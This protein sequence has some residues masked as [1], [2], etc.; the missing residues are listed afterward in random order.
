MATVFETTNSFDLASAQVLDPRFFSLNYVARA[1]PADPYGPPPIAP[2]VPFMVIVGGLSSG[3]QDY[4]SFAAESG[5]QIDA[6]VLKESWSTLRVGLYFYDSAGFLFAS[7][8]NTNAVDPSISYLVSNNTNYTLGLQ[9]NTNDTTQYLLYVARASPGRVINGGAGADESWGWMGRDTL[10]GFDPADPAADLGGDTLRGHAFN[11]LLQGGGGNDVLEGGS[12]D[13]TLSGGDGADTLHGDH[14]AAGISPADQNLADQSSG[15]DR[16][17]GGNGDDLLIGGEGYDGLQGG[18]GA[19][20]LIHD[21]GAVLA[22]SRA[23]GRDTLIG[24]SGN[25]SLVGGNSDQLSGGEGADTLAPISG[26]ADGGEGAD[27]LIAALN[28]GVLQVMADGSGVIGPGVLRFAGIEL[29][30]ITGS[31]A[32]E[33][34]ALGTGNDSANGG[35]GADTIAGGLGNDTLVDG[36][37]GG[38]RLIGEAGNDL[39]TLAGALGWAE[40]SAGNDTLV[41]TGS[42]NALLGGLGN[43]LLR[44]TGGT[45]GGNRL[46]GDAGADTVLAGGKDAVIETGSGQ[47]LI[48]LGFLDG[49]FYRAAGNAVVDAGSA[50]DRIVV[51]GGSH[52]IFGGDNYDVL[53]MDFSR[54]LGAVRI[55]DMGGGAGEASGLLDTLLWE[56][57]EAIAVAG[58]TFADRFVG[59]ASHDTLNGAGG[60]DTLIGGAGFD[61]FRLDRATAQGDVLAD[62]T[63]RGA[64]VGDRILLIGFGAAPTLTPL[65]GNLWQASGSAGSAT[66]TILGAVHASDYAFS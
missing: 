7:A 22:S 3:D 32:A 39:L 16:L 25:D 33:L 51:L 24:G 48:Q 53:E 11:D 9:E 49:E 19:D 44:D 50:N 29:F 59:G 4:F 62:F 14:Q 12:D 43:D 56:E 23:D 57:I 36:G 45:A 18:A 26:I 55:Q 66:F 38:G 46:V 28:G 27:L 61:E 63:G 37:L 17:S 60:A 6:V 47:D 8:P 52:L 31:A 58:S 54:A 21:D 13:D 42:N 2:T 10:R 30:A 41:V 34:I 64:L 15:G 35:G 20:T 65:G 1:H 5:D 40:G